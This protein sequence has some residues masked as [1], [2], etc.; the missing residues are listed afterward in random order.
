MK[1]H[2]TL[3]LLVAS[4]YRCS[5]EPLEDNSSQ[6]TQ[7]FTS[8]QTISIQ[9][10][11]WMQNR[12]RVNYGVNAADYALQI[13]SNGQK[14]KESPDKQGNL[15]GNL[16]GKLR[17]RFPLIKPQKLFGFINE[18]R[19]AENVA[20]LYIAQERVLSKA[21]KD[22]ISLPLSFIIAALC[23]EGHSLDVDRPRYEKSGFS[24]YGLDTFGSEFKYIVERGYLSPAFKDRFT[25]SEK[26]NEQG[27][28]V[29]SADFNTKQDAFEAFM[30]TLAHRQYLFS[31]D[32]EK[33]GI[34][35]KNIPEEQQLFFTYKYYNG[36]PNSMEPLLKK[37]ST[38]ELDNFF[39]RTITRGST[40]N[41]YVV[42][43]GYLWLQMTGATDQNPSGK[44]WWSK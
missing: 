17:E 10:N 27:C 33:N 34:S 26:I 5:S 22:G 16:E 19:E 42:L 11:K 7:H 4:L 2:L 1:K 30:A 28:R 31:K 43:T 32:L 21:K 3:A 18:M 23:N 6:T 15:Y 24:T 37:R 35:R 12:L 13:V 29:K 14:I 36:G 39:K 8:P 25:V 44:Y 38:K 41:A 20:M 40:G 9:D